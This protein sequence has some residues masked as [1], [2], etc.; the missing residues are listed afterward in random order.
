MID[1]AEDSGD[2]A[3]EEEEDAGARDAASDLLHL[4]VA[5][6]RAF[7]EVARAHW[8]ARLFRAMDEFPEYRA[9]GAGA[10]RVLGGFGALGNPSSFH[11]PD[12][13][14]FRRMR[15]K[16]LFRP[17]MASFSRLAFG[18]EAGVMLEALFD[19]L[20]VRCEAFNRPVAEAWHRDIYGAEKYGLRPL[21]HSL[22]GGRQDLLFGG[23]TNLDH[24][25]QRFVGLVA[26]HTERTAGQAGFAEFSKDEVKRFRFDERLLAQARRTYGRTVRTDDRGHV[27]VPPGHTVVFQQ[28]LIHSVVSGP[29]PDTPALR[30]FHGVRLTGETVPLFDVSAA[31]HNGGV[32]RIPSGQIP[33]MYSSNHYQY[34]ASHDRYRTWGESTF[35]P[36]CLYARVTKAGVRYHTPGSRDDR[37]R[38]ANAGRYMPSLSEMGL[39]DERFRYSDAE[40]RSMYP[41][42]LF[43]A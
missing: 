7:D 22:P 31:V 33:P 36:A 23:W 38:A 30:V 9:R 12:V 42:R 11:H 21:P 28:Q 5:V 13:R 10:Q 34:F 4:G 27:R 29:Q 1:A 43:S 17:V 37:N 24:R 2:E 41:Q 15:K 14:V 3:G 40:V 19:R 16:L 8:N 39:W 20:C 32:P 25:E 6:V 35:H 18:E 26:T